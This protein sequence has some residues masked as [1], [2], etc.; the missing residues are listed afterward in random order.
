MD[1]EEKVITDRAALRMVRK[2]FVGLALLLVALYA[3]AW[4]RSLR[5]EW[6]L[7]MYLPSLERLPG[8][9]RRDTPSNVKLSE[10][11]V[12]VL[13]HLDS[14]ESKLAEEE[15]PTVKAADTLAPPVVPKI[16][17][18]IPCVG[19]EYDTTQATPLKNF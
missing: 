15:V 4:L 1:L 17:D 2:I 19:L 13:S 16:P 10:E 18:G 3:T 14:V 8:F 5:P 12:A 9:A 7:S 11:Q 6:L